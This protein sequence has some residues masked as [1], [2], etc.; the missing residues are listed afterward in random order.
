MVTTDSRILFDSEINTQL[1][2]L[3]PV[4]TMAE[5]ASPE[6]ATAEESF[7]SQPVCT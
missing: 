4:H 6:K 2:L 3:L 1:L 7:L 5:E